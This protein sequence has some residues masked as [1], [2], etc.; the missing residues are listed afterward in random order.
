MIWVTDFDYDILQKKRTARG[1][2]HRKGKRGGRTCKMTSDRLTPKQWKELNGKIMSYNLNEPMTWADFKAASAQ[3][4]TEYL[5]NLIK[6]YNVNYSSLS[7]MFG[8]NRAKLKA[9]ILA[10]QIP[11]S[12]R[13]GCSMSA[14]ER[15]AWDEFMMRAGDGL[16]SEI[17]AESKSRCDKH[18]HTPDV[19]P[20]CNDELRTISGS[21]NTVMTRFSISFDG[22][23]DGV[24]IANSITSIAG[25]GAVGKVDIVCSL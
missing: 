20:E 10:N 7:Q 19:T 21:C 9:H 8:I 4:Q 17:K 13:A 16:K 18:R 15:A 5:L 24:T 2:Q 6:T 12:F 25:R 1:A 23:I 3:L 11:V 14:V 22:V